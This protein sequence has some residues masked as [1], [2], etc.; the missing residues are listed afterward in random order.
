MPTLRTP[1]LLA[2]IMAIALLSTA[3][4]QSACAKTCIKWQKVMAEGR[5]AL[6]PEG[7]G[8]LVK[9]FD[10]FT[11]KPGDEWL[12]YGLSDYVAD[13]MGSAKDGRIHYGITAKYGSGPYDYTVAG[14][15]QHLEGNLRVFIK[16]SEGKGG[17]LI[18]QK[19]ILFPYPGNRELFTKTAEATA[20]LMET[21]KFKRDGSV[22]DAVRDATASTEA[23]ASYAKG[24]RALETY[25]KSELKKARSHFAGAMRIDF[26][27][28]LGYQGTAAVDTF[29]GLYNKQ[30]GKAFSTYFQKAQAELARMQKLTKP[31]N[32]VFGYIK[33]EP[34]KRSGGLKIKNRFILG[35]AAYMEGQA[36]LSGGD[37]K[38]AAERFRKAT[39][40]VPEDA[41]AWY[42]LARAESMSGSLDRA[43]EAQRRAH[44]IDPCMG[45]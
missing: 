31:M 42:Y 19:E 15:F 32:P 1:I 35:N 43:S 8:V 25:R 29:L 14:T 33:D 34:E 40:L 2:V 21:M 11:K 4:P 20:E 28:P 6:M 23:Y 10:D 3:A 39:D 27:S 45:Q 7:K 26:R 12:T 16:L 5:I 38:A 17:K 18:A 37:L 9:H 44:A 30:R 22:W 41:M 24:R 36:M 13:L